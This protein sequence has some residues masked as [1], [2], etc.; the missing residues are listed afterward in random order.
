MQLLSKMPT[1]MLNPTCMP[2]VAVPVVACKRFLNECA[3]ARE[4]SILGCVCREK[5]I[6]FEVQ[7]DGPPWRALDALGR[8]FPIP[9][10]S[11]IFRKSMKNACTFR[12]SVYLQ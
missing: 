6:K 5:A 8:P 1:C 9:I 7:V 2:V 3:S 11:Q 4:M 12:C 10:V